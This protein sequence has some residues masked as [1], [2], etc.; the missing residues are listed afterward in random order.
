MP[1]FEAWGFGDVGVFFDWSS[2]YQ[3]TVD[4]SRTAEQEERHDHR[5]VGVG[6]ARGVGNLVGIQM[7][8][9][10]TDVTDEGKAT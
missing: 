6:I 8:L 4:A 3:E 7:L 9:T 5:V 1:I 2:I 10:P